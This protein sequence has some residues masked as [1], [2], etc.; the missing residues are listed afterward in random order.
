VSEMMAVVEDNVDVDQIE[1]VDHRLSLSQLAT[2]SSSRAFGTSRRRSVSHPPLHPP[3][4][5]LQ[6]RTTAIVRKNQKKSLGVHARLL[7]R[8]KPAT[9]PY[10]WDPIC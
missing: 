3:E 7:S 10:Y 9:L 6:I 5:Y 2:G 8:N 4:S 1:I